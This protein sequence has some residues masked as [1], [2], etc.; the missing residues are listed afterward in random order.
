MADPAGGGHQPADQAAQQRRAAPGQLAVV[1]QRLGEPHRDAGADRGGDADQ[2][3]VPR[4]VGRER[5]GE[6]RRQGRDRAVHQPDQ[7]G[8]DHLQHEAAAGIVVLGLTLA[9][10]QA[11]QRDLAR[12]L[13]VRVLGGGEVAQQTAHRRVGGAQRR[14]AIEARRIAF[15][16]AGMTTHRLDAEALHLPGRLALHEAAHVLSAHQRDMR[17]E[18]LRVQVDQGAPMTL[19]LQGHFVEDSGAVGKVLPKLMREVGVDASVLFLGGDRQGQQLALGQVVEFTH[20][21]DVP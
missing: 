11:A 15:H 17:A 4:Q 14:L 8:L 9:R 5:G 19:L 13:L 18:T 6:H 7:S 21:R 10:R 12:G 20:D 2:E 1:R 3:G 16:L